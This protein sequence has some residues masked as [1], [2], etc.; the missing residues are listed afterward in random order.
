[1]GGSCGLFKAGHPATDEIAE[2]PQP[3]LDLQS[4]SSSPDLIQAAAPSLLALNKR[5]S[6]RTGAIELL[7]F[8][9]YILY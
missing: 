1:M 6:D 3:G 9:L 4:S 5:P 2:D 7:I 8:I